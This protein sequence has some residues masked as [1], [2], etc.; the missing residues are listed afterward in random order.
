MIHFKTSWLHSENLEM[1]VDLQTDAARAAEFEPPARRRRR[2]TMWPGLD[3]HVWRTRSQDL[4]YRGLA[5]RC[6]GPVRTESFLTTL[7]M[8]EPITSFFPISL[9]SHWGMYG[10][11]S[12]KI[13]SK[14]VRNNHE[15]C[16]A[17]RAV[18]L[19]VPGSPFASAHDF[20]LA[21]APALDHPPRDLFKV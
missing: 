10:F 15:P 1:A 3:Q 4:Y 7:A 14:G 21:S 13:Y 20:G 17:R 6:L 16:T 11:L 9:D 5:H 2:G 19:G 18:A 8:T 12:H